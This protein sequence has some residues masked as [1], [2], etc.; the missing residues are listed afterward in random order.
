MS[1]VSHSVGGGMGKVE[2]HKDEQRDVGMSGKVR[3]HG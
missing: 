1:Q 3:E 2:I